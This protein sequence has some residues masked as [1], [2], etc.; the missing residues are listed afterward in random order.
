L[1]ADRLLPRIND[2]ALRRADLDEVRA[3]V[4]RGLS[5]DVLEI[6]FGSG[7]NVPHYPPAVRR[8]LAVDP[9]TAGRKLAAERLSRSSTPVEFVGL[10]G[11]RLPLEDDSV[12]HALT[13]FTLCTIP[14]AGRALREV[15]RVLRP[16]GCLHFVEHGLAPEP[17]VVRWQ[18]RLNPIQKRVFGGCHLDRP[19]D[20]LI[21]AAGLHIDRLDTYYAAGLKPLTFL[22]EGTAT[23]E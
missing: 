10:D 1:Y 5:G 4:C 18:E 9:A 3:R 15:R 16:G 7:L 2:A 6:G 17:D 22:Y 23:K 21:E 12:D 14:D 19:I 11:E 8:V 20:R 13:T